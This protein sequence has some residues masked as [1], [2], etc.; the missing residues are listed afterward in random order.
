LGGVL[1]LMPESM[2]TFEQL[3]PATP[4]ASVVVIINLIEG[5]VVGDTLKLPPNKRVQVRTATG[6]H[7]IP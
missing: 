5:R 6:I 1:T 7:E 4:D 3:G 2:I